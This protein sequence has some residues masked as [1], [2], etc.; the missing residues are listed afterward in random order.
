[1]NREGILEMMDFF[2]RYL[3]VLR[4]LVE[5]RDGAGLEA[6]F[7]RSKEQRDAIL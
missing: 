3:A 7:A 1:M 4:S 6:F 2:S 5:K